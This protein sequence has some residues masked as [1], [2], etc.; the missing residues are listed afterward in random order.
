LP[1]NRYHHNQLTRNM[2]PHFFIAD[3]KNAEHAKVLVELL[4]TY[5]NDPMGGGEPLPEQVKSTLVSRL[6]NFPG[7]FTVL[8]QVGSDYVALANCLTGFSTF[9]A[10]PLINI[11][12]LAVIPSARGQGISQGLLAFV[13]SEAQQRK[14]CKVTLEVLEGNPVALSAYKKFGFVPYS[15][16]AK[17]GD[18]VLMQKKL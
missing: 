8:C 16:D 11:H 4:D 5:A 1:L 18:A 14:C 17:T 12:D 9:T 6:A 15:L 7:A 3:Y 13:E 2:T 10:K